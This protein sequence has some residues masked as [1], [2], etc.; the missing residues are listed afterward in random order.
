MK[1]LV[2]SQV[3]WP[4]VIFF[5]GNFLFGFVYYKTTRWRQL[6]GYPFLQLGLGQ[7]EP[8]PARFEKFEPVHRFTGKI[9]LKAGNYPVSVNRATALELTVKKNNKKDVQ[10]ALYGRGKTIVD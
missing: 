4:R 7:I 10:R 9:C 2:S 5:H 8:L 6:F 3:D 1:A